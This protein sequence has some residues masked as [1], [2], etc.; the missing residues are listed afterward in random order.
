MSCRKEV[1]QSD[2]KLFASVFC[3]PDCHET[4]SRFME[5]AEQDLSNLRLMMHETIRH[6]LLEGKLQFSTTPLEDVSKKDFLSA[7]ADMAASARNEICPSH[8]D[9][10]RVTT[11]G[12]TTKQPVRPQIAV[13]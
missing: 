1:T 2:G 5:R 8:Q 13:G 9:T 11:S 3:C 7:L 6:G 4:A 10:T 12:G